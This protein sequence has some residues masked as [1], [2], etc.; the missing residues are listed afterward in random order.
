VATLVKRLFSVPACVIF[1]ICAQAGSVRA[2]F[3]GGGDQEKSGLDFNNGYDINTVGTISGRVVSPP[4]QGGKENVIVE[5]NSGNEVLNVTVG[6]ESYWNRKGIAIN[7]N[8]DL[9]VKGSRA[10]GKD[11]KSYILAQKLVNRTTGAQIDL[12]DDRGEAVWSGRNRSGMRYEG[13]A[14]RM[15]G[16]GAMRGGMM[17][18][19]GGMMR[20]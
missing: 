5:I 15:E 3:F 12:R 2:G 18:N 8:D 1:L 6:P 9:S 7:L 17:R 13:A 20:R 10:Q 19:S 16:A 11:G 4:R 14:G